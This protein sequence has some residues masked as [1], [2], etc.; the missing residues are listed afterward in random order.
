MGQVSRPR[1]S[2]SYFGLL[3]WNWML[4]WLLDSIRISNTQVDWKNKFYG[5]LIKE[6]YLKLERFQRE[7][8]ENMKREIEIWNL[9]ERGIEWRSKDLSLSFLPSKMQ[10]ISENES[11]EHLS[12]KCWSMQQSW[13]ER[14]K[15]QKSRRLKST[16]RKY[17][18]NG[19]SWFGEMRFLEMSAD[20]SVSSKTFSNY[21]NYS[22]LRRRNNYF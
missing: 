13:E 7:H 17:S 20:V 12:R 2:P 10:H 21:N 18:E 9:V 16:Q 22:L 5:K 19:K 8:I 11:F 15:K 6:E 14:R 4:K 3:T 1:D